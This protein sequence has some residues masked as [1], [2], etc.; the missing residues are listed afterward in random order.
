MTRWHT[1]TTLQPS[2]YDRQLAR[3]AAIGLAL[4]LLE[5]AIPSPLPGI[6]PGLANIVTLIALYQ[7]GWRAAVWVSLLRIVA[8]GL[9]LGS[10]FTPGFWLSLTGGASSVLMLGLACH[11]PARY[12]SALSH[13]MLAGMAHLAGQLLLARLW[14]I[15]H[16]G[17]WQLLPPL[18][19][20]S[21]LASVATGLLTLKLLEQLPPCQ[22]KPL[23]S[24]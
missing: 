22:A 12:F 8:A 11:L 14:L 24:P 1:D 15:P 10:L 17:V 16:D 6:K 13:S 23:P 4:S 20:S 19:L 21:L 7:L 5:A 9:M 3:L 2:S 18:M